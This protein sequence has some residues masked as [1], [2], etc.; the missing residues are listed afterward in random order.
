MTPANFKNPDKKILREFGFIM[1]AAIAGVFGLVLPFLFERAW[2]VWPWLLALVFLLL[3]V[4]F[5]QALRYV[6]VG[7]MRFGLLMSRITTPLLLGILFYLVITPAGL[8]WR[9][10][11]GG[12]IRKAG[13]AESDSYR[14]ESRQPDNEHMERPF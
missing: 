6:Y 12:S 10:F 8:V 5:P 3:G 7:W 2:P 4:F 13:D 1:A 11:H 9:M 14:T